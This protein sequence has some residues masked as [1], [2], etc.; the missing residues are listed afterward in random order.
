MVCITSRKIIALSLSLLLSTHTARSEIL[1]TV[2]ALAAVGA[3]VKYMF[4]GE[5]KP[6]ESRPVDKPQAPQTTVIPG[7]AGAYDEKIALIMREWQEDKAVARD[8]NRTYGNHMM[9]YGPSGN[10][11]TLIVNKLAE[12]MSCELMELDA[13][14]MIYRYVDSGA[15]KVQQIFNQAEQRANETGK[16]VMIF[17]DVFE[18]ILDEG[19]GEYARACALA[20]QALCDC[21]KKYKNDNRIF[22]IAITDKKERL[23]GDVADWFED[24]IIEVP[25]PNAAQREAVFKHYFQRRQGFDLE[26]ICSG[27]CKEDLIKNTAGFRNSDLENVNIEITAQQKYNNAGPVTP[28]LIEKARKNTA[29]WLAK[30]SKGD[31][32]C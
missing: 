6:V 17:I 29:E 32:D 25:N 19:D 24:H 27:K 28:E 15:K 22:F 11:K 21:L 2:V 30:W 16:R 18:A 10:G 26:K 8:T 23:K 3:G 9:L 1:S 14:S 12:Q 20:K 4:S 7:M 31:T 13:P 5:S